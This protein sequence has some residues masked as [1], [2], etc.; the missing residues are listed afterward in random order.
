M[1]RGVNLAFVADVTSFIAGTDDIG[2]AL[3]DVVHALDDVTTEARTT[4]TGTDAAL[5]GIETSAKTAAEGM[6]ADFKA[7]FDAVQA[8]AKSSSVTIGTNVKHGTKE[9]GAATGEFRQEAK[10]NLSEVASSF[11]GDFSS[12]ADVVQGTLG[13]LV[14]SFG[15][16]GAI[17]LAAAGVGVGMARSLFQ[18]SQDQA[19]ELKKR[20]REAIDAIAAAYVE[21]GGKITAAT[22]RASLD[23]W[24]EDNRDA[25]DKFRAAASTLDVAGGFQTLALAAQGVPSAV[26]DVTEALTLA[27]VEQDQLYASG[28]QAGTDANSRYKELETA[29]QGVTE[30]TGD[31][32]A[33]FA[34][35]TREGA[36][37][38]AI[39]KAMEG[40]E[41][42]G[43]DQTKAAT[44]AIKDQTKAQA[45]A[46]GK[47]ASYRLA[48]LDVTDAEVAL[49]KAIKDRNKEG[50]TPQ[51]RRDNQRDLINLAATIR[52]SAAATQEQTG[53][54]K[55]ANDELATGRQ[56]FLDLA[57]AM[58]VSKQDAKDLARELGIVQDKTAEDYEIQ[59]T[60]STTDAQRTM[61]NFLSPTQPYKIDVTINPVVDNYL[62]QTAL[63]KVRANAERYLQP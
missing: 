43:T 47:A 1:A 11:Q 8:D 13:G 29:I 60:A 12:A 31:Q 46:V 19:D 23:R 58:G 57:D 61:N 56:K 62:L 9:A 52:D 28:L 48:Q 63:N 27:R 7:A 41:K 50:L 34:A 16:A 36:E 39:V 21:A 38:L 10:A 3:D 37:K 6:E 54:V 55:D 30:A 51:E 26:N 59:V 20:S 45:D 24:Y 25:L 35:G 22:R 44:Q 33:A 5:E 53:S 49:A 4:A 42:A 18:K 40:A 32:G 15:A 14:A 2:A 17:G